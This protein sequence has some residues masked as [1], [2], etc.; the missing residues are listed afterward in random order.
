[1]KSKKILLITTLLLLSIFISSC[2]STIYSSTGWHG[3]AAGSNLVYLAAGNQ[4]Y[5]VDLNTH[6]EKWRYPLKPDT[7]VAFYA[8]PVL[9]EDGQLLLPS[10]DH[11]L[12]SINPETGIANSWNYAG[13]T[14]RLIA[15]PLAT[16]NMIYQPS[17]DGYIYAI[18]M[19]FNEKW[20]NKTGGSIWAQPTTDPICGCIYVASM[21]HY[22]YSF[23]ATDG[24][25][26]WK[27]VDLQGAIVGTPAVGTDGTL[28][29]GTFGKE[30]IALDTTNNGA[31]KWRFS[32]QD[33]IWSGPAFA[34]NVLYFG[35]LSGNFYALDASIGS[36]LWNVTA[37]KPI[38]D[39]PVVAGDN[40]YFSTE[41]DTL[42]TVS[43]AGA[44]VRN[45]LIGGVIYSSPVIAGDIILVAPTGFDS[46]LVALNLESTQQWTYTPAK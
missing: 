15:S 36:V 41:S 39:T 46:L 29:V 40:I 26:L 45:V 17:S 6:L 34:N 13:S 18:D 38:V 37:Q 3:L 22:V 12:Y 2:S 35:D 7:K 25:L 5:A 33:W 32:T 11:K 42:Y 14:N 9:T 16:Q 23:D 19:K 30:M 1:M 27:S 20:K 44:I 28:Y 10:Y 4:V 21:D 8:N 43:T 31:I 24:K